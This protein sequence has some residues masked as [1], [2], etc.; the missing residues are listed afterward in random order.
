MKVR[1]HS[2]SL[3]IAALVKDYVFAESSSSGSYSVEF[4]STWS[5]FVPQL[6]KKIFGLVSGFF[7]SD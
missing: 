4:F 6:K 2:V 1:Q 7:N 3:F 5:V